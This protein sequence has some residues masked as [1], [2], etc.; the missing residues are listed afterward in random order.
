VDRRNLLTLGALLSLVNLLQ[1]QFDTI[2]AKSMATL[3]QNEWRP[4]TCKLLIAMVTVRNQ[5]H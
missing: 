2:L 3:G 5:V 4:Q 1:S